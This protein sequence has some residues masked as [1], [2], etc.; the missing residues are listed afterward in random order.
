M[1]AVVMLCLTAAVP[2][3]AAESGK[4]VSAFEMTD[5]VKINS[6]VLTSYS[7]SS[8]YPA[9]NADVIVCE[10]RG[11]VFFAGTQGLNELNLQSGE[12]K[13][14]ESFGTIGYYYEAKCFANNKIYLAYKDSSVCCIKVFDLLTLSYEDPIP[15]SCEKFEAI[16]VDAKGRIY[17]AA[18]DADSGRFIYL[19]DKSEPFCQKPRLSRLYMSSRALTKQAATSLL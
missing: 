15:F 1:L 18:T 6:D 7:Y 9:G 14:I 17:V 16:G 10:K 13:K 3:L 2:A 8:Y 11:S 5:P 19:L 12:C 4:A